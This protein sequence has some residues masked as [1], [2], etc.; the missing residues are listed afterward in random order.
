MDNPDIGNIGYTG[1][2]TKQTY[3]IRCI[4]HRYT[5]ENTNKVNT[6]WVLLQ[7]TAGKDEPNVGINC[8]GKKTLIVFML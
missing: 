2:Q 5:Q 3:T 6:T 1:R 7:T 8:L 4:G